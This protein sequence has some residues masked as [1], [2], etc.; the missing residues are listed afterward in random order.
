VANSRGDST[1]IG[2]RKSGR[3]VQ[4]AIDR[5]KRRAKTTKGRQA[6]FQRPILRADADGR[7]INP[8]HWRLL[9]R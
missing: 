5:C 9:S 7:K 4:N 6:E 1:S 8:I 2:S 3:S